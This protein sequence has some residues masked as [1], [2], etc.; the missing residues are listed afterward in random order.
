[1]KAIKHWYR[2]P[3]KHYK[4]SVFGDIQNSTGLGSVKPDLTL[5]LALY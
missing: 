3:K 4:N 5:K 1:M 2:F